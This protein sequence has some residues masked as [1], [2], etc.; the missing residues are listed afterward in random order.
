MVITDRMVTELSEKYRRYKGKTDFTSMAREVVRGHGAT[1][2][3]MGEA[4]STLIKAH[5][6]T[7]K[8]KRMNYSP[9]QKAS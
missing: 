9:H 7:R 3:E 8:T 4:T 5:R 1:F 6:A 2:A